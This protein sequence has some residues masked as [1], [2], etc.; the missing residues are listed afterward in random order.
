MIKRETRIL[1][2]IEQ[3]L[4]PLHEEYDALS[5]LSSQ[6]Y[7]SKTHDKYVKNLQAG[8]K[9]FERGQALRDDMLEQANLIRSLMGMKGFEKMRPG[10]RGSDFLLED[11]EHYG[12]NAVSIWGPLSPELVRRDYNGRPLERRRL[13]AVGAKVYRKT[14]SVRKSALA[15]RP[16]DS[17]TGRFVR[18]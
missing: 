7:S 3:Q 6:A 1:E 18:A 8:L 9:A 4:E 2:G 15:A 12:E 14:M 13:P 5:R 17:R 16:R 10:T 11:G